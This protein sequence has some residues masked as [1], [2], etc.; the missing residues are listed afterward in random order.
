MPKSQ[1]PDVKHYNHVI[2]GCALRVAKTFPDQ[3]FQCVITSPPYYQQRDYGH[4]SQIG[5][6]ATREEFVASLVAV[7]REVYRALRDD[8][9]VWLNIADTYDPR[10]KSLMM[11]PARLVIALEADGWIIRQDII[12]S[13]PNPMP[14]PVHDRCTRAHEYVYLLSKKPKY[15]F[16]ADRLRE[17]GVCTK[18]GSPSTRGTKDTHGKGGGNGGINAYKLKMAEELRVHG[19]VTR[20]KRSVWGCQTSRPKNGH[21]A[22]FPEALIEPMITASTDVGDAILDPFGGSG[23][24]AVVAQRMGRRCT[25]IE[26]NPEYAAIANQRLNRCSQDLKAA[27]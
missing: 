1:L 22:T 11:I 23:T 17:R 13:K 10:T 21:F 18:A 9:T 16:R 7:F 14:E 15:K 27:A 2:N 4:K 24:T 25:L 26:L 20:N 3:H 12:W 19:F 8:G 5:L 6:E